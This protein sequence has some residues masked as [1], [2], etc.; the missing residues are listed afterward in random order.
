MT[1]VLVLVR[2]ACVVV[3]TLGTAQFGPGST[4]KILKSLRGTLQGN[5]DLTTT[6]GWQPVELKLEGERVLHHFPCGL[7]IFSVLSSA[8]VIFLISSGSCFSCFFHAMLN[9]CL[10]LFENTS[11]P[12]Y[13]KAGIF[14]GID[15]I[16][17][18]SFI[19][20]NSTKYRVRQRGCSLTHSARTP[21]V[22]DEIEIEKK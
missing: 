7:S 16:A 18:C 22:L 10:L 9:A 21:P 13:S 14:A 11:R 8:T 19:L 12:T 15:E 20:K 2:Y 17:M 5:N 3:K 4:L 6:S 1:T